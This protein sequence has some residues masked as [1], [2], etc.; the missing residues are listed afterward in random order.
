MGN[1]NHL[2]FFSISR[3]SFKITPT[4][5]TMALP[6]LIIGSGLGGVCLAQ[7]FH[8]NNIPFKLFEQDERQNLRTQGYRLR[9]TEDGVSALEGALTPELFALFEQ[10][11]A[12]QPSFGVRVKPDGTRAASS[13]GP[14]GP[15]PRTL[16]TRA[17]TV[18]RATF[19]E[20]LL[21]GLDDH[22]SFGK[23]FDHY[24]IHDDKVIASFADG[25]TEEGSLLVGADGVR[26]HVRNQYLPDFQGIDTRM[27]LIF[28]KTPIT[29]EFLSAVPKEYHN[30]MSLV[31]NGEDP[32]QPMLLFE[33]MYFP[34]A[35]EVL[36]P[37]LPSPYVYWVLVTDH[38]NIPFSEQKSWQIRSQ[39]AAE[40][41]RQ[42]TSSWSPS[43]RAILEMQDVSQTSI[44]SILS[45]L[46][47]IPAWK[48]SQRV[49]LLGD[50]VHVMPP[51]GAMGANTALRD[52]ADLARRVI[53]AGG[54]E[55][56]DHEVIGAYEASLREFAKM[57]IDFSWR[58]GMSTFGLRPIEE[59]E[60]IRLP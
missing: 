8:K 60:R 29:P 9:I 43:L 39:E 38:T 7:S 34:H 51:T 28:G 31:T 40:L 16:S 14:P 2:V 13:G 36:K 45:A 41:A 3:D 11:C 49:T 6:V 24:A 42:L 30:G 5:K 55:K 27:R 20:T 44:R 59:C 10:T 46:P 48:P 56:V 52:A 1:K 4:Y 58:G 21:T 17:H 47:E 54:A 57:A 15:P 26:S 18:D 22:V 37:Q 32:C 53:A 25:S 35:G 50:A 33:P 12:D 23:R 19:R